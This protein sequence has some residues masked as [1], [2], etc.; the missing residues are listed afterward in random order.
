MQ[1]TP[2]LLK[3]YH[4]GACSD[5]ER[6]LVETWLASNEDPATG[7]FPL[8]ETEGQVKDFMWKHISSFV[9]DPEKQT[10]FTPWKQHVRYAT[11]ACLVLGILSWSLY[12]IPSSLRTNNITELVMDNLKGGENM[13]MDTSGLVFTLLPE[14]KAETRTDW[15][16]KSG[17]VN[18]CGNILITNNSDEDI[19]LLFNTN[20]KNSRYTQ[21]TLKCEKG[22]TY[23]AIHYKFNDDEIM[24]FDK[25]ELATAILPIRVYNE[26]ERI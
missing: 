18:F 20:C 12:N 19:E 9:E 1:I 23:V 25:S 13:R 16:S 7:I 3:Q 26:L 6:L 10:K 21:K 15:K 17:V 24:V 5:E 2:E 8:H 22:K 4:L 11:A 14:S